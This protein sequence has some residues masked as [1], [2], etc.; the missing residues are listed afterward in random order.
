MKED[1]LSLGVQGVLKT[2][3]PVA[4]LRGLSLSF[5][6]GECVLLLGANGAG[7]STLLRIL[8][9]LS[10]ADKGRVFNSFPGSVGFLSHHLFLYGRLT[11]RENINLFSQLSGRADG[12]DVISR[13]GLEA[14]AATVVS[15]LS[16]GNQS[17]TA[18]ARTFMGEPLVLLLDEPSSHL[19]DRGIQL[20]VGGIR[21][22][23]RAQ[24]GRSLT[25]IATH[26]IH[27]L[28]SLATRIVMLARGQIVVDSG[29]K[30][31]PEELQRVIDLY[32]ESNR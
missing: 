2:F 12:E 10:R 5:G 6:P 30:A 22:T 1:E 18:L 9:G 27:R 13:W 25:V 15:D 11:V 4:V 19:D 17:R 24:A 32:R 21:D 23:Q 26:D 3:G 14:H 7:K 20:L 29:S 8:A 28:G 31:T 16:K